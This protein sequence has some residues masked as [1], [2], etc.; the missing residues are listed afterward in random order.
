MSTLSSMIM[1]HATA[2]RAGSRDTDGTFT[3]EAEAR[4]QKLGSSPFQL[5]AGAFSALAHMHAG[6]GVTLQ[7]G[8]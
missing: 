8:N 2:T 6:R 3:G 5:T 7:H 4:S 1:K